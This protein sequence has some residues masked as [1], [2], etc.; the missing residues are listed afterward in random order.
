MGA[1]EANENPTYREFYHHHQPMV[2][3]FDVEHIVL[4]S[5]LRHRG[6]I[7]SDVCKI[8]PFGSFCCFIPAPQ[9][10]RCVRVYLTIL[11]YNS[12]CYYMHDFFLCLVMQRYKQY[13]IWQNFFIEKYNYF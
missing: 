1:Y 10:T 11:S 7:A 3:T 4:S 9:W 2:I 13:L 6:E 8:L 12:L 5:N